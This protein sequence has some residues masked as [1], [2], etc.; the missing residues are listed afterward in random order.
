M[1]I[2]GELPP[3]S[4]IVNTVGKVAYVSQEAWI[5]NGSLRNNITFGQGFDEKRYKKVIEICALEKV[6]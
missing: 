6:T 1:A 5:F 2:L 3:E 4:G